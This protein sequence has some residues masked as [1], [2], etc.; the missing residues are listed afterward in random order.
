MRRAANFIRIIILDFSHSSFFF[1]F[2]THSFVLFFLCTRIERFAIF[3]MSNSENK[4]VSGLQNIAIEGEK[5]EG[6]IIETLSLLD[7]DDLL[8]SPSTDIQPTNA[9]LLNFLEK[10][11]ANIQTNNAFKVT[12]S[13]RL[14]VLETKTSDNSERINQLESQLIEMKTSSSFSLPNG[15]IEQR[16]LSNNVSI[17]GIKPSNGEKLTD[18]VL[19]IFIFYGLSITASDIETVYRVKYSKSNMLIVKFV[20]FDVKSKLM[21]AKKNRK[22]TTANIPSAID[23]VG[24]PATEVFINAHVTPFVGRILHRCRIAVKE[25]KLAACWISAH[26]VLVKQSTE[27]EPIAIKSMDDLDKILGTSDMSLK[28]TSMAAGKR[29]IIETSPSNAIDVQPKGRQ[30]TNVRG[31]SS[32]GPLSSKNTKE[33]TSVKGKKN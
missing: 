5:A 2:S 25:R 3:K 32:V 28:A 6:M 1:F 19:D 26:S 11:N 8:N 27:G 22:L 4:L 31:T 13:N 33:K 17:T 16:K 21:M 23:S 24:S 10:M 7:E 15:W 20:C 9:D 14:D 18:I 12:A 29:R 30:R